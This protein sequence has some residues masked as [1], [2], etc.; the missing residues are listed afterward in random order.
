MFL[1]Q[2]WYPEDVLFI[3]NI[4]LSADVF[5]LCLP[6]DPTHWLSICATFHA[7]DKFIFCDSLA[8]IM[9]RSSSS[10]LFLPLLF[11]EIIFHPLPLQH[12]SYSKQLRLRD[13]F[14]MNRYPV[15]RN[16]LESRQ[17]RR[18]RS[19]RGKVHPTRSCESRADQ[20]LQITN[21]LITQSPRAMCNK[22]ARRQLHGSFPFRLKK[23]EGE[24]EEE[25]RTKEAIE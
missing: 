7:N 23:K 1:N 4:S 13:L 18:R 22:C 12:V 17:G 16:P 9:Q 10:S 15:E 5:E 6:L 8:V 21:P 3:V 20:S 11:L 25:K 14:A 2:W 24:V 19:D